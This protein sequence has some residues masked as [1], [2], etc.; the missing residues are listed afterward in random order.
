MIPTQYAAP[1]RNGFGI[2]AL[3]LAFIGAVFGLVPLTGFIALILGA[4]A[5]LFGLLGVARV[6]K[7]TASNG[8]M[9]W[10]ATFLGVG[11]TALGI[12]GITMLVG[13]VQQFDEDMSEISGMANGIANG[14]TPAVP[15]APVSNAATSDI[16]LNGCTARTEY[17]MTM[18]EAD[19]TILNSLDQQAS[20]WVTIAVDGADGSRLGEIFAIRNDLGAGQTAQISGDAATTMLHGSAKQITCSVVD[21]DRTSF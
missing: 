21:V 2:T 20:Y 3:V 11:V 16:T 17:G 13:A 7:G 9:S 15:G 5:V 4:L 12:W 6:R 10:I 1:A 19:L 18:A 14:G 8:V